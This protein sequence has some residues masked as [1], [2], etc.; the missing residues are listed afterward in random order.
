MM[1]LSKIHKD[2]REA[3]Q[4]FVD[5]KYGVGY[6]DEIKQ[7]MYDMYV[8]LNKIPKKDWN[9]LHTSMNRHKTL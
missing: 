7:Q 9:K 4:E 3:M 8:K 1:D 6:T 2:H 5:D